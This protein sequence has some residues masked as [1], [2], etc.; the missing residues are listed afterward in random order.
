MKSGSRFPLR[1]NPNEF[2]VHSND[3]LIIK[4]IALA[5]REP[6]LRYIL[7]RRHQFKGI[8]EIQEAFAIVKDQMQR[9]TC[10]DPRRYF[11]ALLTKEWE[12]RQNGEGR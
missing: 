1:M 4:D 5:L 12:K 3:D 8:N 11:N 2:E 9:G 7:A 6:D 10:R